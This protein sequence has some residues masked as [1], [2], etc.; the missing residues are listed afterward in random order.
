MKQNRI[1]MGEPFIL[2]KILFPQGFDKSMPV[3]LQGLRGFTG[4]QKSSPMPVSAWKAWFRSAVHH[5]PKDRTAVLFVHSEVVPAGMIKGH[6]IL[7]GD[8]RYPFERHR[9]FSG[10]TPPRWIH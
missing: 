2:A 3:S 5:N 6:V 1:N 8:F 4:H 10:S 7:E 9:V